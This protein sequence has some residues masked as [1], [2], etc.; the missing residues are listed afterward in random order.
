MPCQTWVLIIGT[1]GLTLCF[2]LFI[3]FAFVFMQYRATVTELIQIKKEDSEIRKEEILRT[4]ELTEVIRINTGTQHTL[5][6]RLEK[7]TQNNGG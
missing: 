6:E 5:L 4:K 3:L 2:L 7:W 1:G